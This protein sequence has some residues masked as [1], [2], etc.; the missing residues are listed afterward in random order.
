M[1]NNNKKNCA[2]IIDCCLFDEQMHNH[3]RYRNNNKDN[4]LQKKN[5][6]DNK[7]EF[8][9]HKQYFRSRKEREDESNHIKTNRG[10]VNRAMSFIY[11]QPYQHTGALTIIHMI[12][13]Q[14]T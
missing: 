7:N 9:K 8:T 5:D 3:N 2:E 13:G 11:L 12:N 10:M 1:G 4:L 14:F 6:N